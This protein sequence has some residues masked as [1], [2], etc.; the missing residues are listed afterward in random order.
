MM[1]PAL[2][3]GSTSGVQPAVL[4]PAAAPPAA[5]EPPPDLEYR[6]VREVTR[7]VMLPFPASARCTKEN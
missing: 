4:F 3:H 5:D 2:D 6:P 1:I 7:A